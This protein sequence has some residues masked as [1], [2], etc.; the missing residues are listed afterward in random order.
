MYFTGQEGDSETG[1][2]SQVLF[3]NH[4]FSERR[5]HDIAFI[6]IQLVAGA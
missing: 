5:K 2:T 3:K 4:L 1:S 6:R